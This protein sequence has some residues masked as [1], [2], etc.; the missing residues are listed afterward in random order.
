MSALAA[1]SLATGRSCLA[2]L[3]QG[4][5][6]APPEG[7]QE[8]GSALRAILAEGHL[9]PRY[10]PIVDLRTG[11]VHGFEGLIRGP[12]DSL[13]HAP[14]SLFKV[15]ELTRQLLDLETAC[16]TTLGKT[17]AATGLSQRLFLNLSPGSLATAASE[18]LVPLQRMEELGLPP[19]R[20]V[21][22]LTEALPIQDF[23]ILGRAID[24]FRKLGFAIALDDLGEGFSGLRLWSEVRPE[25][26]KVDKHFIQ[27]VSQDPV[28]HQFLRSL[29]DIAAKTGAL[30]IAEGIE[31]ESDLAVVLD[32]GM[33][34]GQGYLLGR[35]AAE[36]STVAAKALLRC[37][38]S[39]PDA[40][41]GVQEERTTAARLRIEVR[42]VS[43]DTPTRDVER[44]FTD[45]PELQSL[46]V[47]KDGIPV[48]LVN[49]HAFMDLMI[50][51]FSK[52][53][54]GKKAVEA[55]MDR[56]I[57]V[58]D[59]G[60]GLQELSRLIVES[61]PRHILHG[62][63]LT[64]QGSYSGMGSGHDLMREIT[65]MQIRAAR[66]ANPLT[67]LPGNVPINE[68][69]DRLLHSGAPF[70]ACHV[71]LDHFKPYN[72]VYGYR[73]GDEV[74]HWTGDLLR[75][76][77][78]PD[79]DFVGHIGGDDFL[80][81]L[82]SS[83]WEERCR[84]LLEAFETGRGRFFSAE[85]LARD[86]YEGEDRSRRIVLHPLL[87]V[88]IGAVRAQ[89]GVYRSHHEIAAAAAVAKREAKRTE[90]CSLFLE[91]RGPFTPS[92]ARNPEDYS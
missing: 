88:S 90:G 69:L 4:L 61:D 17:Y 35:P 46:P 8:L 63:I 56:N 64:R 68:H 87:S 7:L 28:K 1:L 38:E 34:F 36:P 65:Q 23:K 74:I 79:L 40:R 91:R 83:D 12:S 81:V 51:P 47:V 67:G 82:R 84:D 19:S 41:G 9:Q 70:T 60:T 18:A 30:I 13:L 78:D 16:C 50:R 57:L 45:D 62:F 15:A 52:E 59:Q 6:A 92:G 33:D 43:P 58:V 2:L 72:D 25:Y 66:Y 20:I 55:I 42:S 14:S 44:R 48:G 32:L 73:R 76:V 5:P 37:R 80:L 27:G 39:G 85:D 54:Y 86:G 89:P 24:Q 31:L 21:I 10:Q 71:D 53:V 26:V 11:L 29:C 77:A 22:E 49:R 3:A 75:S